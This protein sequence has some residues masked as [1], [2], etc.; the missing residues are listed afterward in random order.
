MNALRSNPCIRGEKPG[1][2]RCNVKT[3]VSEMVCK[4][5]EWTQPAQDGPAMGS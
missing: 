4:D 5:P 2:N 3:V 1:D